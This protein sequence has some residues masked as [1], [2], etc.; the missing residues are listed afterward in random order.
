MPSWFRGARSNPAHGEAEAEVLCHMAATESRLKAL[1]ENLKY[2]SKTAVDEEMKARSIQEAREE[3]KDLQREVGRYRALVPDK[4]DQEKCESRV[5]RLEDDLSSAVDELKRSNPSP[6]DDEV[7]V[8]EPYAETV[9]SCVMMDAISGVGSPLSGRSHGMPARTPRHR[10]PYPERPYHSAA[11]DAEMRCEARR[12]G[13]D[14]H[15]ATSTLDQA[16]AIQGEGIRS[17]QATERL[18]EESNQVADNIT[19]QL[20]RQGEEEEF[21][22]QDLDTLRKQTNRGRREVMAFIRRRMQDKCFLCLCVF[23]IIF[24]ILS[25]AFSAVRPAGDDGGDSYDTTI[26]VLNQSVPAP[27]DPS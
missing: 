24:L 17:L 9:N 1:I 6:Y 8:L 10:E 19:T 26:Y 18:V 21:L 20:A 25:V 22:M 11:V 7:V 12:G 14:G 27:F 16:L 4:A 13:A 3:L 2:M 15:T 5:A 23:T